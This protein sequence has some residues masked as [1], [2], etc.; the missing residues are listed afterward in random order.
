MYTSRVTKLESARW[1]VRSGSSLKCVAFFARV[2]SAVMR[3]LV[4]HTNFGGMDAGSIASHTLYCMPCLSF[5]QQL[6][7]PPMRC[8]PPAFRRHPL[9]ELLITIRARE[10]KGRSPLLVARIPKSKILY[11]SLLNNI[12]EYLYSP[13]T[14]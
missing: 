3:V 14:S 7:R 4:D 1:P 2:C 9:L 5:E 13:T 8:R 10:K 11:Q 6:F 12:Y